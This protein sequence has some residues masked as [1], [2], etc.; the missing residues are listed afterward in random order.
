[1]AS[2]SHDSDPEEFVGSDRSIPA[3]PKGKRAVPAP[4]APRV[5]VYTPPLPGASHPKHAVLGPALRLDEAEQNLGRAQLELQNATTHLRSCELAES[6]ALSAFVKIM[7][8]PSFDQVNRERL[9]AE[10]AEKIRRVQAGESPIPP[11]VPTHGNSPMDIAA[12]QRPRTSAQTA[13]A[14]LRSATVRRVV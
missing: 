11:K 4:A 1:M 10:Q 13:N 8:G 6:D 5:A 12:A 2:S 14:P 3:A 7:P 9:A